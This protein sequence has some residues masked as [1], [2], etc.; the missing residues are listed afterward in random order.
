MAEDTSAHPDG[1]PVAYSEAVRELDQILQR[2][3][4]ADIDVDSLSSEVERAAFL[5]RIC[6]Q[7]ITRAETRIKDV[8]TDMEEEARWHE[9]SSEG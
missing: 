9:D 7:R 8:L 5:L 6:R 1:E 4:V 2:I 3:E